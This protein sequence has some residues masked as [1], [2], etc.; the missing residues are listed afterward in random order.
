MRDNEL[1]CS[2][3]Q[4]RQATNYYATREGSTRSTLERGTGS[5]SPTWPCLSQGNVL[6]ANRLCVHRRYER[7]F[8]SWAA[9][10]GQQLTST[11][12]SRAFRAIRN[13][14]LQAWMPANLIQ[15]LGLSRQH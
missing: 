2:K 1:R 14:P 10:S 6:D 5:R 15:Q 12:A 13:F 11:S 4:S 9:P 7:A 8:G 3:K